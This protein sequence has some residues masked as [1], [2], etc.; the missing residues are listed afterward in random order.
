MA[1]RLDQTTDAASKACPATH[2]RLAERTEP[3]RLGSLSE[4][5]GPCVGARRRGQP[6]AGPIRSQHPRPDHRLAAVVV[7]EDCWVAGWPR[8]ACFPDPPTH[9]V[10][11]V[12]LDFLSSFGKQDGR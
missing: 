7:D 12:R 8:P 4:A 1:D 5:A 11:G 9:L 6:A 2:D 10:V 3:H